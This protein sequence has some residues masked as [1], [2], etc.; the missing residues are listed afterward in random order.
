MQVFQRLRRALSASVGGLLDDIENHEAVVTEAIREGERNAALVLRHR[1]SC[2]RRT[3]ALEQRALGLDGELRQ[4][5]GR[6]RSLRDERDKALECVR[7]LRTATAA[8]KDTLSELARQKE[9]LA[10]LSADERAISGKLDE[11]RR[12]SA[13]LTSR[14][15]RAEVD[16]PGHDPARVDDVLGRWEA[17]VAKNEALSSAGARSNDP[18]PVLTPAEETA[19]V[20]AE[21]DR[22]LDEEEDR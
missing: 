8:R 13:Q 1:E 2:E 12:R 18:S 16:G 10:V 20:S 22:L 21:L 11:L 15:A 5:R 7:R 19:L 3:E 9:L 17:R 14:Q 4:W 6:A